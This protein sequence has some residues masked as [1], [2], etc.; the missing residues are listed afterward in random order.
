M[1]HMQARATYDVLSSGF[2]DELKDKRPFIMSRSTFAGSGQYAQHWI[3]D[4]ERTF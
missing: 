3:G 1:G 2:A 4:Q